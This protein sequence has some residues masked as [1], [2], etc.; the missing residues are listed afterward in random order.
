MVWGRSRHPSWAKRQVAASGPSHNQERGTTLRGPRWI[1]EATQS[2]CGCVTPAHLPNDQKSCGL[3][4]SQNNRRFMTGF[5]CWAS[6]SALGPHDAVDPTVPERSLADSDAVWAFGRPS[7]WKRGTLGCGS[8]TLHHLQIITLPLRDNFWPAAAATAKSL[9]LCL[10]LCDPIDG[11]PPGSPI[12]GI[13]QA[14]TL[15]WVAISFSNAWKWKAK[16]KSLSRV[17]L[18][19]TP[20]TAA[21]Q[22]PLS[23][24]FSK[25]EHWS[26]VPLPS[27]LACYW[28]SNQMLHHR[29]PSYHE[30]WAAHHKLSV[31]WPIK[32]WSWACTAT[33]HCQMEAVCTWSGSAGR[34]GTG[35][36]CKAAAQMLM[37]PLLLRCLCF[38]PSCTC[39]YVVSHLRGRGGLG[40]VDRRFCWIYKV[41]RQIRDSWLP[42]QHS[43]HYPIL[44]WSRFV[45]YNYSHSQML[46]SLNDNFFFQVIIKL[47]SQVN[48]KVW[49]H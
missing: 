41:S 1:L 32:P 21:Y 25:E 2:S 39:T 33:R 38:L 22:A 16:V 43:F 13:L 6:S 37:V 47:Q 29:L 27:P 34:E 18:V 45:Y 7:H 28:A 9:Q 44:Q 23:M 24:G 5:G 12:P 10:T 17:R 36:T 4:G 20:W 35:K 31:I 26:G 30:T 11:S 48:P 42:L 40:L 3:R 8:K 14:R 19:V 15:E 46:N 49:P